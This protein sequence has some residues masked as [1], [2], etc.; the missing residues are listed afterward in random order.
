MFKLVEKL[1]EVCFTIGI[2]DFKVLYIVICIMEQL[3]HWPPVLCGFKS[4][5]AKDHYEEEIRKYMPLFHED[6]VSSQE[7]YAF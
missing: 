3:H 2:F 4:A 1:T 6:E 5:L 7:E